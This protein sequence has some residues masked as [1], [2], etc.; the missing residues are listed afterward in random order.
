MAIREAY[1]RKSRGQRHGKGKIVVKR[2]EYL[3][4][5]RFNHQ[6]LAKTLHRCPE[7]FMFFDNE[8]ASGAMYRG[9]GRSWANYSYRYFHSLRHWNIRPSGFRIHIPDL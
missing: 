2:C 8:K 6:S 1:G 3:T 4:L 9:T 5:D 7:F